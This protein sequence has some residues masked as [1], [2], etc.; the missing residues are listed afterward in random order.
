MVHESVF[1]AD[2]SI[3]LGSEIHLS[4][5]KGGLIT[6]DTCNAAHLLGQL[7][8]DAVDNAVA[9]K[10]KLQGNITNNNSNITTTMVQDFHNHMRNVRIRAVVIRLLKHLNKVLA[11]DLLGID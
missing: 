2:H 1:G 3:P 5:L 7:M 11:D 4:K 10:R 6:T 9:E 8:V